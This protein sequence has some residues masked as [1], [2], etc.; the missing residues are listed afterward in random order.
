[1]PDTLSYADAVR[2]LGGEK[3]KV[4][5]WFDKLTGGVLLVASVP[6]PAL[7]GIFDA[8][9]EFVRL[10]HE[11]VRTASEKR[12]GLSRYGR[13]QRLE[14]AHAVI[15]VTAFF[16]ALADLKLPFDLKELALDRSD[17][18]RLA[19]ARH[20]ADGLTAALF[21]TAAPTP[22]PHLSQPALRSALVDWYGWQARAF[23]DFLNG[24]AVGDRLS[25]ASWPVV[26]E[27]LA[28]LPAAAVDLYTALLHRLAVDFPEVSF[29]IDLHE[30]EATRVE[31]R[32]LSVGLTDLH[33]A[34]SELSTGSAPSGRRAGLAAAYAADLAR[35]IISSGD[36]PAGLTV[37]TLGEAYVPPLCRIADLDQAARPGDESWWGDRSDRDDLWQA[38]VVHFTSPRAVR[39]P[40]LVLGQPGSGKSVLTRIIAARLPAADFLVV[41]VVLRDVYAAGDIQE[42]IEEAVRQD[43]GERVEW[44]A[45]ARSA[46][47]ALPVVLLDGF[48]ELLQAT[49]ASQTDYLRR[50][51]AFQRREADQGRPVAVLV[52]SRTSVADR[53]QP[54]PGT[55]AV[56]LEPFDA[57]RVDAWVRTW[58]RVNAVAFRA[59]GA[60]P[61][62]PA[63][64]LSHQELAGQPLLL[65]MLALYDAEGHDLRQAGE[66]RR[67]DLYERLLR[68]FARREVVKHRAG[69]P[70][71]ELDRAVEEE[72]C[73]LAVVAF[74]MFNR[75]VQWVSAAELDADLAALPFGGSVS[76]RHE[77]LRAPL[78]AAEV[79]LGRFFFIHRARAG[80]EE[81]RHETYEFLHAT[82]GEYLVARLTAQAVGDLIARHRAASLT[83]TGEPVEDDLLHALLSYAVLSSRA[84]VLGFIEERL[85]VDSDRAAW[86]D[87]LV[88]L[89]RAA[90]Y[91][92]GGRHFDGYRPRRLR[93]SARCAAYTANLLLLILVAGGEAVGRYLFPDDPVAEW[94]VQVGLWRSQLAPEEWQSLSDVLALDRL[95]AG[96]DR[97]VRLRLDSGTAAPPDADPLWVFGVQQ[98]ALAGL[99]T[100]LLVRIRRTAHLACDVDGAVLVGALE[101]MFDRLPK[102]LALVAGPDS[103]GSSSAAHALLEAWLLP[104]YP[105]TQDERRRVYLGCVSLAERGN[106]V[107]PAWNR[108]AF[109]SL[110]L[111]RMAADSGV[112]AELVA[113]VVEA[114]CR[115]DDLRTST[116]LAWAMMRCIYQALGANRRVDQRLAAVVEAVAE[117]LPAVPE[118]GMDLV[119]A[120]VI[121]RLHET[122]VM[123]MPTGV[124]FLDEFERRHGKR[125][126]DL[127]RRLVP[128]VER[129]R[130]V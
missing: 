99:T 111:D 34:L 63:T 45:L 51:A 93:E 25:D 32:R 17:Q 52:T 78:A 42:Q 71:L 16:E 79:V 76:V 127:V 7:L 90:P 11:L 97:D 101:P 10:G 12:S 37:P 72:L 61:L 108:A 2:L 114:A 64:V 118:F 92:T 100:D 9:A 28:D 48:D 113:E 22:G 102:A 123:T 1:M 95:E 35:P 129:A 26:E 21:D 109:L 18:L 58:N 8:K 47:D 23:L 91:A 13:T 19:G 24:L 29:W 36:V 98:G 112:S 49:G 39:A 119:F 5:D 4:V 117:T 50:V 81:R 85:R 15:A 14:A 75:G 53:A 41:R 33:R 43:T 116:R 56:R 104:L 83:L 126:P 89:F 105:G 62:D 88:R 30:H 82:F 115:R 3:S 65:L 86:S 31:V 96:L 87:L 106:D 94:R 66:L 124:S 107:F 20:A 130:R 68:R 103:G 122:G 59:P 74:A 77:G 128:V 73:R 70:D 38:L 46:G 121:V 60:R 125:R 69:L 80:D 120:D 67:G 44:P 84:T 110:L 6:V 40:L 27:A 57:T 55:V 54:P